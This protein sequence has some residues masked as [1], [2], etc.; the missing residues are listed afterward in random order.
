[1]RERIQ[2]IM[3]MKSVNAAEFADMMQ[4]KRPGLS[5]ILTGR[6]NPSLDFVIK[7]KDTFPEINLEWLLYG[8]GPVTQVGDQKPS[9]VLVQSAQPDLFSMNE[10]SK[11]TEV[12]ANELEMDVKQMNEK[13]E[14]KDSSL[15]GAAVSSSN[16]GEI[17]GKSVKKE[18]PARF[19]Q[20]E[21]HFP[22]FKN[23]VKVI[24]LY[25]DGTFEAFDRSV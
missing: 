9:R 21:R 8:R 10:F 25:E 4:I 11:V 24:M 3:K 16:D 15:S 23:A 6:N 2:Q 5:H 20:D 17:G 13:P 12:T 22:L 18:N 14:I 7:L 1:M 19:G